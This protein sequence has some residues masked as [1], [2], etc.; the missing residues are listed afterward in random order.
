[1]LTTASKRQAARPY[2]GRTTTATPPDELEG[3]EEEAIER[4]AVES[5]VEDDEFL[6]PD[7]LED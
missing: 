6:I 4:P 2:S 3:A 7:E 1:M 5:L